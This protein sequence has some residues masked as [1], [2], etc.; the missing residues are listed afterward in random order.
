MWIQRRIS[1]DRR[2]QIFKE[3]RIAKLLQRLAIV[4]LGLASRLSRDHCVQADAV[5]ELKIRQG[6][7]IGVVGL[8][9]RVLDQE[10]YIL[11]RQNQGTFDI[12]FVRTASAHTDLLAA[13]I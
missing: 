5:T 12:V 10:V 3:Q 11:T 7:G 1:V 13:Q 2:G 9:Y 6:G 8:D 4:D